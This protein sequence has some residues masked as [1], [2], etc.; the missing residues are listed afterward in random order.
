MARHAA[1]RGENARSRVHAIN[2]LGARLFAHKNDL[3]ARVSALDGFIGRERGPADRGPGRGRQAPCEHVGDLFLLRIEARE[4]QLHQVARGDAEQ[5]LLLVDQFFL[6]H[7]AGDFHRC[8]ARALTRARLEHEEASLFDGE[9]DV[10]HGCADARDHV[11]ALRV[12]QELAVESAVAR[13][14]VTRERDTRAGR[15]AHVAVDHRLHVDSRAVEAVDALDAP[16]A[17]RL[18]GVPALEHRLDRQLELLE[19]VLRELV[20]NLLAV[21]LFVQLAQLDQALL[22]HI[23]V[24][25]DAVFRFDRREGLLKLLVVHVHH[26]VAEHVDEPAVGVVREALVPGRIGQALDRLVV[27]AEVQDRVHHARHRD[28][29]ARAH[30]HEQRV[31]RVAELLAHLLLDERH[32]LGDLVHQ[33]VRQ[34]RARLVVLGARLGRNGHARGYGQ[35]DRG[36]LGEVGA[37]AAEQRLHRAVAVGLGRTEVEDHLA[38]LCGLWHNLAPAGADDALG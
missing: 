21:D 18:V 10:L 7:V 8:S 34:A 36:H 16:V 11:L 27:Q 6:H 5:R 35:T 38:A 19:R 3:L 37:L 17:D 1:R 14:G 12:D 9:L 25:L 23:G 28:H 4:Q 20:T 26:D 13:G 30:R 24:E 31:L 22:G 15:L 32:A 2:V 33:A 29:R